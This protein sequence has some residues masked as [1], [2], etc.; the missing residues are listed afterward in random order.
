[1]Y[2][3]IKKALANNIA[4]K[5][6]SAI[7]GYALWSIMSQQQTV[8]ITHEA[9]LCFY[10]LPPTYHINAPETV[11]I[12]LQGKRKHLDQ[13]DSS[14]LAIHIN[15]QELHVGEQPL[16]MNEKKLFLPEI[17]KLVHY[18]PTVITIDTAELT[19]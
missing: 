4:L 11:A 13:L 1:M 19:S 18:C 10:N 5:V 8:T 2:L 15:G 3:I 12:S 16:I 7:L 6:A 17:I 9:H 14:R